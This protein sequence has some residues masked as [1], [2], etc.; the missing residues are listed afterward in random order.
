MKMFPIFG[1]SVQTEFCAAT[2]SQ[3]HQLSKVNKVKKQANFG[4]LIVPA[5]I[6]F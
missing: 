1:N 4:K 3:Q 6:Y 2:K 5:G